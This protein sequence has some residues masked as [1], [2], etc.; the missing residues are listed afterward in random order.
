MRWPRRRPI[1]LNVKDAYAKW[2]SSYS[3]D[4]HNP[5]MQLEQ[6]AMIDLLPDPNGLRSIDVACGSGR[7]LKWLID[8]RSALAC[9]ID[10]SSDMLARA[11]SI[12]MDLAEADCLSLPIASSSF[13]LI[14]CGLA[15]G[16]VADLS[17]VLR[18]L[19]RVV[20][21]NGV[22]TYSDFHP[23]GALLGWQR[24][25]R[26]ESGHEYAVEHHMHL[27]EDH[28]AA[29]QSANLIIEA[30]REPRLDLDHKWRGYPAVLVIRAR[31]NV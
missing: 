7:Y 28:V 11:R 27:Y 26:D 9:G 23:I 30:V 8:H 25:F 14:V 31:K 3:P 16:H 13:D 22:I 21:P 12:S 24:T 5:L 19:A 6:Q 20:R 4:A 10:L 15:V 1:E 18:E 29:C 2:A 17:R